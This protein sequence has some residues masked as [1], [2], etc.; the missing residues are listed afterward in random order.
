[1]G[2]KRP[3]ESRDEYNSVKWLSSR[4]WLDCFVSR[5]V[6]WKTVH[7]KVHL[8][9]PTLNRAWKFQVSE[10]WE[11]YVTWA[12]SRKSPEILSS[13]ATIC[14]SSFITSERQ[15]LWW[16]RVAIFLA[17]HIF[18]ARHITDHALFLLKFMIVRQMFI[19][20]ISHAAGKRFPQEFRL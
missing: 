9:K 7:V 16:I 20:N 18:P 10:D 19:Y 8:V 5:T 15:A 4:R 17:Q 14:W 11:R 13:C 6:D 2:K 3:R 1:M 12:Q